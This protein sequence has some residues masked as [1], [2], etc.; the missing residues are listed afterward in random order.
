MGRGETPV[1]WEAVRGFFGSF[2]EEQREWQIGQRV[3]DPATGRSRF[4]VE[5]EVEGPEVEAAS[6]ANHLGLTWR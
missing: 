3:V 6:V 4:A 1:G 2:R 5:F